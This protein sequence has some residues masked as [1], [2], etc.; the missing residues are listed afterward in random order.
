MPSPQLIVQL[1]DRVGARIAA[2]KGS[3][4]R[5]TPSLTVA[6]PLSVSVGATL[7]T[8]TATVLPAAYVPSSSVAVALIV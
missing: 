4:C 5:S 2:T 6:A 3:A 1:R 8:V 7:F